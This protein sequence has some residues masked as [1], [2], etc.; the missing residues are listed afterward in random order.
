M[1]FALLSAALPVCERAMEGDPYY[2]HLCARTFGY[3][4][5]P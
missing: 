1:L 5:C 3:E 4:P 2:A